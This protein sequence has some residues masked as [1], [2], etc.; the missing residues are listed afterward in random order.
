VFTRG[1]NRALLGGPSTSPLGASM[2]RLRSISALWA[3]VGSA[4]IIWSVYGAVTLHSGFGFMAGAFT[5]AV[6]ATVFGLLAL[7]GSIL[8]FRQRRAG[9]NLLRGVSVLAVLYSVVF[10]S[11]GRE[12]RD[13]I[14]AFAVGSLLLLAVASLAMLS[15]GGSRGA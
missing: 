11:F 15:T 12:E 5:A 10:F 8:T 9:Q 2:T 6:M 7:A 14:Y 4:L 3:L 1:S 13:P